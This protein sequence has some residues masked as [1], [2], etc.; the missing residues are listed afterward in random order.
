MKYF[1]GLFLLFMTS[2]AGVFANPAGIRLNSYHHR[3]LEKSSFGTEENLKQGILECGH[4]RVTV[5]FYPLLKKLKDPEIQVRKDAADALAILGV[6]AAE[7][8]LRE[9]F[10]AEKEA[11]VKASLVRALGYLGEEDKSVEIVE[12]SLTD[13]NVLIRRMA[14]RALGYMA[15]EKQKQAL[16]GQLGQEKNGEVKAELIGAL[17][18]IETNKPEYS[19]QLAPLLKDPELWVR[20]RAS[21]VIRTRKLRDL[22]DNLRQA[23]SLEN[24]DIVREAMFRAWLA[25]Q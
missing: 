6:S 21:E 1:I 9:A 10:E 11:V 19:K 25:V 4:S 12:K 14:A 8:A 7:S 2:W 24:E 15:T 20:L 16:S 5:C 17:L 13:E 3:A 22:K 23:M 18:N